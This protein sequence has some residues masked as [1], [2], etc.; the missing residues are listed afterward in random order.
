M[1]RISVF[2]L[3]FTFS[4]SHF[5]FAEEKT[6]F[7]KLITTKCL[8]C[9]FGPGASANWKQGQLKLEKDNCSLTIIFDSID[10]DKGKARMIANQ[11]SADVMVIATPQSI[12]FIEPIGSGNW[13]FTSV[14]PNYSKV[15][16]DFIAVISRHIN[17]PGGPLPSQY[18]GTCKIWE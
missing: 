17:M 18:H 3:L 7:K 9:Q 1:K 16:G 5:S 14:F 4:T 15:T 6:V 13:C 2:I 12:T 10:I 8:K 11:G